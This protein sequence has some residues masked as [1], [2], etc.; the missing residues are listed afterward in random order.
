M[1]P[2][3]MLLFLPNDTEQPV[4]ELPRVHALGM[5]SELRYTLDLFAANDAKHLKHLLIIVRA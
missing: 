4:P 1:H 3:D 2:G 5:P